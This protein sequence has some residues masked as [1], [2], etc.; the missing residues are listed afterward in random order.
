MILIVTATNEEAE[1]II[2]SLQL[3]RDVSQPFETYI[4]RDFALVISKVGKVNAAGAVSYGVTKFKPKAVYNVGS[5]NS[6]HKDLQYSNI[7][8]VSV[9]FQTDAYL[10]DA[11]EK[12]SYFASGIQLDTDISQYKAG[13]LATSDSYVDDAEIKKMLSKS[14]HL[15]DMEGYAVARIA[16][17]NEIPCYIYKIIIDNVVV[18]EQKEYFDSNEQ[19]LY[20]RIS[21]LIDNLFVVK[22]TGLR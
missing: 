5:A 6:L 4:S 10:P 11:S 9:V 22:K 2:K 8:A 7:T 15:A 14:F 19:M 1:P 20:H 16:A 21:E 3:D 17:L 18:M 12:Y 13:I